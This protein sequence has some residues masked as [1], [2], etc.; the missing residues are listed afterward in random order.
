MLGNKL[1]NTNAGG[2]CTDTVDLYNPFPDGGGVALYQLN[3]N[4]TDVSGNYD[5]TA[6]NVTYG[7]GQFGQAGVFNGSSSIIDLPN[8]SFNFTTVSVSFWLK[9]NSI[10]G[11]DYVLDV[12]DESSGSAR[13]YAISTDANNKIKFR[14]WDGGNFAEV[15]SSSTLSIN[16]W[17]YIVMVATQTSASIYI[18]GSLDNSGSLNGFSFHAQQSTS[19]GAFRGTV[20][21]GSVAFLDGSLDQVRIFSRALRP[22]EVEALYTEEYCTPTIVPSEHFNTVLYTGNG[23]VN[24]RTDVGFQPDLVWIKDMDDNTNHVLQDSVRGFDTDGISGANSYIPLCP[25]LTVDE[26]VF[27][28]IW[29]NNYGYVTSLDSNGFTVVNGPNSTSDNFNSSG[30]KYVAWNFK[31]GGSAVTNTDGVTSGIY[32]GVTSQ[33]SANTDSGFSIQTFTSSGSGKVSWGHGLGV[34]PKLIILKSRSATGSWEFISPDLIGASYG[35]RLNTSAA[36]TNYTNDYAFFDSSKIDIGSSNYNI[37]GATDYVSYA[38]AEVEGFS[39]FGSY[40]GTGSSV[41]QSIV[42][43]FEPAFVIIKDYSAGGSWWIEDNKRGAEKS[44]KAN[45]SDAESTTNYVEFLE[46]G[47]TVTGGLNDNSVGSK[48]IYMAF[49]ADPTTIEPSLEDSFNTVT[50]TGSGGS[51][52]ISTVGFQPDFTWIKRRSAFSHALFDSVRGANERLFSNLT[53]AETTYTDTL[54]SFDSN[55]FTLG[56]SPATNESGQ[57]YV[58]WNWKGAELPAINSNGSI[59][60]V[61]SANP[62][63]GFS[64]VSYTGNS[65]SGATVGHGLND[66]PKIII[67]KRRDA[68]AN[69]IIKSS[70]LGVNNYLLFTTEQ[71]EADSGVFWNSTLPTS[72]VF[73]LGNSA[74]VNVGTYISYC[75]AEVAG[76]SKFGSYTGTGSAGNT[77][78]VGF[79]PAFVMIKRT[80]TTGSWQIA[81]NK[82][83]TTNPRTNMLEP[84]T[85]NAENPISNGIDFNANDFTLDTTNGSFN[86]SGGTYI[87]MAFANQ[88]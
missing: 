46:N 54:M 31:A 51:E 67:Y 16:T 2:G 27:T 8:N 43:G 24:P 81:D 80:D 44:L 38:F 86:G 77:V 48:F 83:N 56:G 50:W 73:T 25:N 66:A 17:Y 82:R 21:G 19:I 36:A 69:W 49:A 35:L 30:V 40:A 15:F 55:G 58:A 11:E 14:A 9:L 28:S 29:H 71:T 26:S 60:S 18:N 53:A 41:T 47:F 75:F 32:T 68:V 33:V 13:G 76:F 72:S 22:Y 34:V 37:S 59:P 5:G 52:S 79:E 1:I 4:A 12:Y 64:I 61:V 6:S 57:D 45:S 42:T 7:A 65:V 20:G 62:A 78:T 10:T 85:S 39:N 70:I 3:G 63:A 84:N 74:S 88:F 87:Y 23:G